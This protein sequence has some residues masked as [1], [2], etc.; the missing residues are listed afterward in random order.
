MIADFFDE[1]RWTA[2]GNDGE[3]WSAGD[4]GD[5]MRFYMG[6]CWVSGRADLTPAYQ[7]I[8]RRLKSL[9]A[10]W[11]YAFPRLHII[12]FG[13]DEGGGEGS[14]SIVDNNP[15]EAPQREQERKERAEKTRRL[16]RDLNRD[17]MEA[18]REARAK[19]PPATVR[20][21]SEVYGSFP[22]GWPP[23]PYVA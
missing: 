10:D 8:F 9:G 5:Y 14:E 19:E 4:G 16:R 2:D 20:A 17:A 12:D 3:L 6:T 7:L 18:K 21:Y 23:D 11:R 22:A 15:S 13:S 1:A